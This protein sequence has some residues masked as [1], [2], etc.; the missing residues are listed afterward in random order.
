[1]TNTIRGK[2]DGDIVQQSSERSLGYY[3]H[4]YDDDYVYNPDLNSHTNYTQLVRNY[5]TT[6]KSYASN[7]TV[8]ARGYYDAA[9]TGDWDSAII[10]LLAITVA[11]SFCLGCCVGRCG[12]DNNK[13]DDDNDD[14][15]GGGMEDLLS[16]GSRKTG[17][18]SSRQNVRKTRSGTPRRR[19]NLEESYDET[20]VESYYDRYE[21]DETDEDYESDGTGYYYEPPGSPSSLS[22]Y[23][24]AQRES[25]ARRKARAATKRAAIAMK[26]KATAEAALAVATARSDTDNKD[27]SKE[28]NEKTN[29]PDWS[30]TSKQTEVEETEAAKANKLAVSP[31]SSTTKKTTRQWGKL[32]TPKKKK[33][34]PLL[35]ARSRSHNFLGYYVT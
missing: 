10:P 5:E 32:V 12:R 34:D 11:L 7:A 35:E 8:I 17:R 15:G 1:M 4:S 33:I 27:K 19:Y 3:K 22:D 25:A 26:A 28:E 23:R 30:P 16:I 24:S 9:S 20:D 29:N 6:A 2:R 13:D 31:S 14:G 18:R 21:N